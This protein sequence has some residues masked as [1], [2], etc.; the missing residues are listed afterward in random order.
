M[1]LYN[2]TVSIDREI[3]SDWLAW[4]RK[5]HIPQVMETGCFLECRISKIQGEED[6]GSAYSCLYLA[7]S[8]E[9][10]DE[11]HARYATALQQDQALRY[12]GKFDQLRT[13]L[14]VI[15]EFKAS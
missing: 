1:V 12:G 9:K 8:S 11:Y 7:P 2:V 13:N 3:E 4:M 15:E 6:G 14:T 5:T 10:L